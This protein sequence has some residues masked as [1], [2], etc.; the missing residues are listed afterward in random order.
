MAAVPTPKQEKKGPT[1]GTMCPWCGRWTLKDQACNHVV[2]GVDTARGFVREHGCG[3][4]FCFQC[5]KKLCG[6]R[7]FHGEGP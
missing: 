3:H 5:G 2:C 1:D 4:Q 6:D 7:H